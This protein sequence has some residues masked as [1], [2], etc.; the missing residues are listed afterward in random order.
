MKKYIFLF[1]LLL[2]NGCGIF[3][4]RFV[5]PNT[6]QLQYLKDYHACEW[7]AS[8]AFNVVLGEHLKKTS[9]KMPKK[10]AYAIINKY[11]IK[12]MEERGYKLADK[13]EGC[14]YKIIE[15]E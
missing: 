4:Q 10:E 9:V 12:C 7:Y 5:R 8:D 2:F 14:Y 13:D 3:N 15:R 11:F 6:T 1:I